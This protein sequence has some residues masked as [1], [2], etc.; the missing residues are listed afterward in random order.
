MTLWGLFN[1]LGFDSIAINKGYG[2]DGKIY[3]KFAEDFYRT[4]FLEKAGDNYYIQRTFPSFLVWIFTKVLQVEGNPIWIVAFF[5]WL[6]FLLILCSIYVFDKT[7]EVFKFTAA[8][9][10]LSFALAFFSFALLKAP[11]FIPV[12]TD[13]SAFFL[14]VLLLH[15]HVTNHWIPKII[16]T[17][18]S[19]F[20]WPTSLILSLFLFLF[21]FNKDKKLNL[22]SQESKPIWN[23]LLCF[24]AAVPVVWKGYEQIKLSETGVDIF[25]SMLTN[26]RS[27]LYISLACNFLAMGYILSAFTPIFRRMQDIKQI[28]LD[29][30]RGMSIKHALLWISLFA[31]VYFINGE[32]SN[33][34]LGKVTYHFLIYKL[35]TFSLAMPLY[36][37]VTEV[38]YMGP[39]LILMMLLLPNFRK[40]LQ[41]DP[42]IYFILCIYFVL[43]F[44]PEGRLKI[45]FYPFIAIYLVILLR[46]I[47]FVNNRIVLI[48]IGISLLFSKFYFSLQGLPMAK[49]SHLVWPNQILFM[50][51]YM[52]SETIYLL[53]IILIL[54]F[55]ILLW[56]L[57]FPRSNQNRI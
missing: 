18:L 19:A 32:F 25:F 51:S 38:S 20:T 44:F 47:I 10:W 40:L 15:F 8:E 53:Q 2:Y 57:I 3:G 50:S 31:I 56:L 12:Q 33:G 52:M 5:K 30:I 22:T 13:A 14:A 43:L 6:N 28:I 26:N 46:Q 27:L 9:R 45:N 42:G 29:L 37:I 21:P 24:L 54:F 41:F 34:E 7:C 23:Y 55:S 39:A 16:V 48:V 11:Y 1:I 35:Y 49:T 4:I 17:L 36:Y